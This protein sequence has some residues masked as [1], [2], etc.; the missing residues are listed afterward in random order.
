MVRSAN[1]SV[2][3]EKTAAELRR[4][5]LL[6]FKAN[7]PRAA[8]IQ[9]GG[10]KR[11]RAAAT[12]PSQKTVSKSHK[13]DTQSVSTVGRPLKTISTTNRRFNPLTKEERKYNAVVEECT[14]LRSKNEELSTGLAKKQNELQNLQTLKQKESEE[15]M[16]KI[17]KLASELKEAHSRGRALTRERDESNK[18]NTKHESKQQQMLSQLQNGA[19]ANNAL[20][21]RL[22]D[23]ETQSK[24][25][26]S[27]RDISQQRIAELTAALEK[28]RS[29]F[30]NM[31]EECDKVK[32]E[33]SQAT[34]ENQMKDHLLRESEYLVEEKENQL[35]AYATHWA[36]GSRSGL[37]GSR[38][39]F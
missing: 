20:T 16:S 31:S 34:Q 29:E 28:K 25:V 10:K 17:S 37:S 8:G 26:V 14:E 5:K 3:I 36:H 30:V 24:V 15:H 2:S 21:N 32:A 33:L 9:G 19:A 35:R 12:E 39:A 23:V 4:E 11:A 22:N 13:Q 27:E 6:A 38:S 18:K 7:K 1:A